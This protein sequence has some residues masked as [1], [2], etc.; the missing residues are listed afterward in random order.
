M[1][2]SAG[3]LEIA[4]L[5]RL[6]FGSQLAMLT[7]P[8]VEVMPA[9]PATGGTHQLIRVQLPGSIGVDIQLFDQPAAV[10]M[11]AIGGVIQIDRKSVV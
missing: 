4:Q 1:S 5:H 6:P 8:I 9:S 11:N 2:I 10:P 7:A 3:F